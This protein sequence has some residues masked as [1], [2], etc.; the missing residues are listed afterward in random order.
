MEESDAILYVG[1]SQTISRVLGAKVSDI[2]RDTSIVGDLG[3]DS[4]DEV[5]VI[6][7]LEDEFG[8]E[9]SDDEVQVISTVQDYTDLIKI[10]LLNKTI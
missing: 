7:A 6:I 9:I 8:I 2:H 5:D 10:K 4:L 3:A 1:V